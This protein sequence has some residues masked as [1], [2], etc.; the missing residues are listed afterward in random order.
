M[1]IGEQ[2]WLSKRTSEEIPKAKYDG[3]IMSTLLAISVE[4]GE[5]RR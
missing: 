1:C 3:P 5:D 2:V 4:V